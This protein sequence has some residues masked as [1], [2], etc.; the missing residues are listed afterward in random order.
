MLIASL[1]F[2]IGIIAVISLQKTFFAIA[3]SA[4][5]R[6]IATTLAQ[7]KIDQLRVLDFA[8]ID[9]GVDEKNV[10]GAHSFGRDWSFTSGYYNNGIYTPC[11]NDLCD[12]DA[13][14]VS[15]ADQKAIEVIVTWT[16]ADSTVESVTLDHVINVNP[17]AASGVLA[18]GYTAGGGGE[19]PVP[20]ITTP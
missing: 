1:I 7:N 15:D 2:S 5:A 11:G 10:V 14:G 12:L 9:E 8:N 3:G 20:S 6:T 19:K 16:N 18:G 17:D 13:D 4:N